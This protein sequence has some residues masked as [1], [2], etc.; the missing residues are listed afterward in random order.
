MPKNTE[1][2][3]YMQWNK[4]TRPILFVILLNS[5]IPHLTLNHI[6]HWE[7]GMLHHQ[8]S[9]AVSRGLSDPSSGAR[10]AKET[11]AHAVKLVS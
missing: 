11:V 9:G 4:I 2:Y 7:G 5:Q 8:R 10:I 6:S 1:P 3:T